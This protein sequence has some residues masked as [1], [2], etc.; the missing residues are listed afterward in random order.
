MTDPPSCSP[1]PVLM[2]SPLDFGE[3]SSAGIAYYR[4]DRALTY[5][6]RA[7]QHVGPNRLVVVLGLRDGCQVMP[8]DLPTNA[9][10]IITAAGPTDVRNESVGWVVP[11][12]LRAVILAMTGL[13]PE[14]GLI[15]L[16]PEDWEGAAPEILLEKAR[17]WRSGP[18]SPVD[19]VYFDA[20]HPN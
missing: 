18:H 13:Q 6:L 3:P 20:S 19:D 1:Q 7:L 8:A 14:D 11:D 10:L 5:Y 17:R 2:P 12:P 4:T 16:F 9:R 15:L